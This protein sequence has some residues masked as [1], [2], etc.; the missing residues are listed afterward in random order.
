M[1]DHRATDFPLDG[2]HGSVTCEGCHRELVFQDAAANPDDCSSCHVD[3]HQGTL[4]R[5]CA[6]CHSTTSFTD[7]PSGIVHPA[8]FAL[9]G[10][11]LQTSC[12]SCHVDDLGGAYA[13]MDRE[14]G[15]C[16]MGDYLSSYLVDHRLLGFSTDCTECHSTFDF[17]DVAFDHFLVSGGF[18]L[19]GRH[20]SIECATCH[21]LPGGAVD[22]PVTNAEDCVGCHLDDYQ[23][24][25]G[26]SGFPTDCRMCHGEGSWDD[27]TFDHGATGF[28]LVA[29]HDLLLCIECHVGS[30]A[31]TRFD[32]S[33]PEDCYACHQLDYEVEH[34]GSGFPTDCS[35]CHRSTEWDG[36]SF[37]HAFPIRSGAHSGY[38]CVDCHVTPGDLASF[39]CLTCHGRP[40][41]DDV[42]RERRGYLYSS[43]ACLSCH[44][45]GDG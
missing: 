22:P 10:A 45:D 24:E 5:P 20:A 4:S 34:G 16:H 9:D 29:T 12:E 28:E 30:T 36:A 27:A 40:K 26:G 7:L 1:F 6:A 14:C 25:H 2:R 23:Q 35:T 19:N 8:D 38:D 15:S 3:V 41:M 39:T 21:A 44:R 42:H 13:P 37:E 31:A 32:P 33:G 18:E 11:H 17:R 43:S